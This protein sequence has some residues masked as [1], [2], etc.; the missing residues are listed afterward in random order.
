[1]KNQDPLLNKYVEE[2]NEIFHYSKKHFNYKDFTATT[3]S[4]FDTLIEKCQNEA[5]KSVKT[6][7]DLKVPSEEMLAAILVIQS[8]THELLTMFKI[9]DD[10][11]KA[12]INNM[13]PN[14]VNDS[15]LAYDINKFKE[16]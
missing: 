11:Y 16:L 4:A 10:M 15:K 3:K 7:L 13:N 14:S 12:V 8:K 9:K 1:M 2:I 6:L 5:I